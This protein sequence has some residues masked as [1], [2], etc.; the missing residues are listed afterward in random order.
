MRFFFTKGKIRLNYPEC[1]RELRLKVAS[2]IVDNT[3]KEVDREFEYIIPE[4]I[5]EILQIGMRVIVPFGGGNKY[6]EGYVIDIKEGSVYPVEKLK[7]ILDIAEE[8]VFF[9]KEMIELSYFLKEKYK[10]TFS[11]AIKS[12][13][14]AGVNL[15]EN[16]Y[17][18]LKGDCDKLDNRRYEE[19]VRVLSSSKFISLRSIN[20]ILN[21][22]ITRA[23]I[24]K[25]EKQGIVEIKREMKQSTN[26][27]IVSV[28]VPNE[29][30]KCME[31]I[32]SHPSRFKRQAEILKSI[33]EDK[34]ELTLSEICS[35][36]NCSQS[37]IKALVEKQFLIKVDKE[38]YRNPTN[39]EYIYDIVNLTIEQKNAI[40]N[41][42]QAHKEGRNITLLHGVTGCGKTEI[43]LNLVEKFIKEGHGAIVLVPE[44][45]LTPQTVERFKGRFGDTVAV[46]HSRLSDGERFDEWRRTKNGEVKVVVGARSAVLSPVVNLKLII[47]DEEHEYSYKSEVS[48]KYLTRE[49][50][51]YRVNRNGGLLVLG[52]ATPSIE[53]Y[54]KALNGDYNLVQISK[55]IGDRKLPEVKIVDMKNEI[56]SG[57]KSI[58]SKE[59]FN[60]IDENLKRKNQTILF[61]NRR[62]YSTFVSCRSCGYVCKCNSCDVSLTYHIVNNKLSCHYCGSE[63]KIPTVCPKCGSKYIKYFGAGT[64]KIEAEIKKYFPHAKV[65][66]MD[67]DTTRRKGEHERI[68]NDF[69]NN[70]ADILV[71]TQMITKGMD[72]QNVTL[73]GV[74]AADTTLNLPDFRSAERTFQLLTQVSGRAGRGVNGG[75]VIIQT[76]DPEHYSIELASKHDYVSFYNKEIELRRILNNPPFSDIIHILFTS[77]NEDEL[78]KRCSLLKR[79]FG[80]FESLNEVEVLGPVP[81]YISKIKNNYRWHMIFK[82]NVMNYFDKI[83][84]IVY[85]NLNR[86]SINYNIDINPYSMF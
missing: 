76:Y 38:L 49:V 24:F 53:S 8:E 32:E 61:L 47:I 12:V 80:F 60:A 3:A 72:F 48:P 63:F 4:D 2:V 45:S 35:K 56:L 39:R 30:E 44:I 65:L 85:N 74:I 29:L 46:I 68:Y 81:C 62:G 77:E 7:R 78:V 42:L 51:E 59:L 36:Y 52:S 11:E 67:M 40:E 69:K 86:S 15:K 73:V 50:A 22:K 9:N 83:Q 20:K 33:V 6:L 13:M 43:Y 31:F 19:I 66:R 5:E 64:E 21:S 17:V 71:G 1:G 54:Y 84:E 27:K 41:I 55:R 58:F 75:Q 37:V 16:I 79:E 70:K 14:P 25:M 18:R 57:N 82:G 23:L 28:Y 10:C 26:K 34:A